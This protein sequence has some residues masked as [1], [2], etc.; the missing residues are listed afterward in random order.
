M[1]VH[2]LFPTP[3]FESHIDVDL[4]TID[5]VTNTNYERAAF[6]DISDDR[7]VLTMLPEL[8]QEILEATKYYMYT[9]L[10]IHR[11]ITPYIVRSWSTRHGQDDNAKLHCHSNAIFSGVYYVNAPHNSGTITFHDAHHS[12]FH[13]TITPDGEHNELTER[14]HTIYPKNGM[15]LI[16]PAHLLHHVS[17][18]MTH[19]TR[20]VIGFDIFIHGTFGEHTGCKITL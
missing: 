1:Q 13:P 14:H 19:K 8:S 15:L 3:V 6:N 16:F 5:V 11:H 7:D 12:T 17:N 20:Y 10:G 4:E 2:K 18:N 9:Q